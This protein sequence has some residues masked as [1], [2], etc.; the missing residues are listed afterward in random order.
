MFVLS[1]GTVFA[2]DETP[3]ETADTGTQIETPAGDTGGGG[4]Q[5]DDPGDQT[6]SDVTPGDTPADTPAKP[7]VEPPKVTPK[8]A[9]AVSH[10]IKKGK[11]YYYRDPKTHKIRKKKGFIRDAGKLYYIGKKGRIVTNK[12]FKVKKKKYRARKNGSIAVGVYKWKKKLNYSDPSTG[13]WIKSERIVKWKGHRYYIRKGGTIAVSDAFGYKNVPYKADSSGRL[14]TLPI[15]NNGNVVTN[16]AK[17][18][19]GIMTGKTYWKWYFHTKFKNCDATPWCGAFVA[20]CFNK[21]GVYSKVTPV[22]KFG[23]LGF[24]PSYSRYADKHGKWIKRSN[25]KGGDIVIYSGSVHVGLVEGI[26]D[27]CLITIEG[28]AGPTALIRGKP[29]AVVRK[30]CPLNSKKIKGVIRVF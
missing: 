4:T 26:S 27:G 19:V 8:P 17:K 12:T 20:W 21:A 5:T 15:P 25:A 28:N 22:K 14:K 11:Y 13:Q 9:P 3:S 24:V 16:V 1:F 23:N 6:G 18:Q 2:T 7:A 29:G 30:A 10:V